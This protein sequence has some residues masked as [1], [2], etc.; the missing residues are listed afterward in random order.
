MIALKCRFLVNITKDPQSGVMQT[1]H[2]DLFQKHLQYIHSMMS[3]NK[4]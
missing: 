3:D 4:C 1:A 2:I